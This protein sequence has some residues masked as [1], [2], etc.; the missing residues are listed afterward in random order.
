MVPFSRAYLRAGP[1]KTLY[2]SPRDVKAAIVTCGGLCPGLNNIIKDV[3]LSLFNLYGAAAVYGV[4]GGYRGFDG[5]TPPKVLTCEM[6]AEAHMAGGTI[7]GTS[8]GGFDLDKI[9]AYLKKYDISQVRQARHRHPRGRTAAW[10]AVGACSRGA[11]VRVVPSS[12]FST[13][14]VSEARTRARP[15]SIRGV[16]ERSASLSRKVAAQAQHPPSPSP[17]LAPSQLYVCGGDGTHRAANKIGLEALARKLNIAVAGIP[18]TIDND[19]DLVDRSFGFNSAVGAAQVGADGARGG[20]AWAGRALSATP[21]NPPPRVFFWPLATPTDP[22]P[23]P[24]FLLATRPL[25]SPPFSFCRSPLP[26]P[27]FSFRPLAT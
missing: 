16:R 23:S 1:R 20:R 19:L 4:V 14:L 6:V 3:T 10:H 2:F 9:F 5:N 15:C 8:R 22:P 25:L 11:R 12:L 17:C 27:V 24:H 7:L 21:P 13:R 26:L 18:K